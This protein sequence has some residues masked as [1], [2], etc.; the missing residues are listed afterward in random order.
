MAT[1]IADLAEQS[2]QEIRTL[3]YLL[4]PPV[5]DDLGL[6]SALRWLAKG[7]GERSGIAMEAKIEE[8]GP[9]ISQEIATTVF[10]VAQEAL[11][12]VHRHS[13]STWARITLSLRGNAL[14]L[15]VEDRG[16]GLKS[17][18]TDIPEQTL[19]VG[20]AGMRVRLEQLRGRLEL[21][22]RAPG[23]AVKAT[24]PL[25][26]AGSQVGTAENSVSQTG[27][28]VYTHVTHPSGR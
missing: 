3:S 13:G 22:S 23:L 6:E 20:I 9:G 19:G 4:H 5:L 7:F 2:L 8:I 27:D 15:C 11:A 14:E 10:R 17:H 12:N 25:Q 18:I 21:Q 16:R 1:E 28:T 26:T 24:V